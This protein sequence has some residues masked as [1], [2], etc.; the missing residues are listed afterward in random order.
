MRSKRVVPRHEILC[1]A[2]GVGCLLASARW[3]A[4]PAADI[5]QVAAV[6]PVVQFGGATNVVIQA[7]STNGALVFAEITNALSYRVEG[8]VQPRETWQTNLP[9]LTNLHASGTGVVTV[10]VPMSHTTMCYRVAAHVA[11]ATVEPQ[12]ATACPAVSTQCPVT[13]TQCPATP[14]QC[15]MTP[16]LCPMDPTICTPGP[17]VCPVVPTQCPMPTSCPPCV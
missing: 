17:S 9:G 16:T 2:L 7:F 6:C 1:V 15:P 11:I 5:R 13:A 4:V 8:A 12:V 3:S 14:T 10:T